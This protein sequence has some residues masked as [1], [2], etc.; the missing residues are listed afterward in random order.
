MSIPHLISLLNDL[1]QIQ[2]LYSANFPQGMCFEE[3]YPFKHKASSNTETPAGALA[4]TWKKKKKT[5]KKKPI[6]TMKYIALTQRE[7]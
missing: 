6:T 5:H 7:I 1:I 4:L 2:T 3:R